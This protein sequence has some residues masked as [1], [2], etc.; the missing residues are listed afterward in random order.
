MK[1]TKFR[2][3]PRTKK[4]QPLAKKTNNTLM[5]LRRKKIEQTV[6]IDN[7]TQP[8]ILEPV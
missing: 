4:L 3:L 1:T 5:M 8:N 7:T 6:S 2:P